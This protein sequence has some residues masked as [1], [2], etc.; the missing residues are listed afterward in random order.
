MSKAS[1]ISMFVVYCTLVCSNH[2]HITGVVY[3]EVVVA[4][5]ILKCN[6]N[7]VT[8]LSCPVIIL[9]CGD[10]YHVTSVYVTLV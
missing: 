8:K 4:V 1:V 3:K 10:M 6:A 7:V 2:V 5:G 9:I